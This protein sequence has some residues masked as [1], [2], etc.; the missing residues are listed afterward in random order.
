M[1]DATDKVEGGL[2]RGET[3]LNAQHR[4]T[5]GR[6]KC[7]PKN[8]SKAARNRGGVKVKQRRSENGSPEKEK[9]KN[10]GTH[11]RA[12]NTERPSEKISDQKKNTMT[13]EKCKNRRGTPR[14]KRE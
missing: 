6:P 13:Q 5:T 10:P 12:Q 9:N 14:E 3:G 2:G 7:C 11:R 4:Q 8:K 1:F